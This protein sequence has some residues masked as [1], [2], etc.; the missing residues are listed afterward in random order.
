MTDKKVNDSLPA[1]KIIDLKG[2]RPIYEIEMN[3][4]VSAESIASLMEKCAEKG[5][6]RKDILFSSFSLLRLTTIRE[7]LPEI[8]LGLSITSRDAGW[9]GA[10]EHVKI[11][12]IHPDRMVANAHLIKTA[13]AK[14]LRVFIREKVNSSGGIRAM[15]LLG[16]D[17]VLTDFPGEA[18]SIISRLP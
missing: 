2:G 11:Y 7:A 10:C 16:V 3:K 4:S 18:I 1:L 14:G 5:L 8:R 12:S 13:H 6:T 15:G 9:A 17:G